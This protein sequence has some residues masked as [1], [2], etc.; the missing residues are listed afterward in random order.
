MIS[1]ALL[2]TGCGAANT[3][4]T[5][6]DDDGTV[7][8]GGD[9]GVLAMT[10]GDCFDDPDELVVGEGSTEVDS[11]GAIPCTDP[12]DN[13]VFAIFDMPDGVYLG[14]TVVSN[15]AFDSCVERFEDAVGEAYESSPLAVFPLYPTEAGW[16]AGDR[17][18]VC[19]VYNGD[20]SKL[21]EDVLGS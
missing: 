5:T 10:V 21:T 7:V 16:D 1:V 19:S 15:N 4:D 20:L 12:H 13:Q 3:D 9:L 18:V 14:E 2:V 8:E 11:V 17:E 6:R